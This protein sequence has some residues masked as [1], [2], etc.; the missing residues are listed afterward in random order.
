MPI[1]KLTYTKGE[2]L[3]ELAAAVIA[4]CGAAG[5][6]LLAAFG[7]A[8][9]GTAIIMSLMTLIIYGVCTLC[10]TMPQHTN[11]FTHPEK[12]TE[13]QLRNARRGFI[14]GKILFIAAL[15]VVTALGGLPLKAYIKRKVTII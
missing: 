3:A 7:K 1:E 11:V 12:C 9:A 10:S 6:I 13:K 8:S 2:K 5:Y 15:L 14:A 4:V